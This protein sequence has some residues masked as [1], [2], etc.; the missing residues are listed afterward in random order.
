MLASE[1]LTVR[2]HALVLGMVL[3]LASELMFFAGWFATYFDLRGHSRAWPP[4]GVRLDTAESGVATVF[5]AISSFFVFFAVRNVRKRR[6]PAARS[7]LSA[8]VACG[9]VFLAIAVHGWLN[10]G[11]SPWT[12]PYGSVFYGLTGFHALHVTAGVVALA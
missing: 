9:V 5:L 2:G 11:F 1:R 3:F 8:A 12:H 6:L 10:N 7:W 4:P